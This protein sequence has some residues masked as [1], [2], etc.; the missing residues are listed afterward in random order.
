MTN[1]NPLNDCGCCETPEESLAHL[2]PPG[3]D[4]LAYRIGTHARFKR[5]MVTR[6]PKHQIP[7]GEFKDDRPLAALT[8]RAD[9]DA[10]LAL[11]DAWATAADVLTFYQERIANEGFL[12]T[13]TERLSVLELAREIGYELNPGV[14]ASTYL[15]F[16][17]D[18]SK[19]APGQATIPVGTQVQSLPSKAGELPQTFETSEEMTAQ[20]EWNAL[21][22]LSQLLQTGLDTQKHLYLAGTNTQLKAGDFVLVDAGSPAFRQ[23]LKVEPDREKNQTKVVFVAG[24]SAGQTAPTCEEDGVPD[25]DGLAFN[26]TNIQTYIL[27]KTWTESHL[28]VF[29]SMNQW[30]ADDLLA[31]VS[32]LVAE[33]D[34]SV[35]A[36]RE[37]T[38]IFG[39]TAPLYK[40]LPK[41]TRAPFKNWDKGKGWIIWKDNVT[42]S[43]YTGADVFLDRAIDGIENK[44]WIVLRNSAGNALICKVD[45]VVENSV[46]G[47]AM[48]AKVTGLE[49][50]DKNGNSLEDV[51]TD[52]PSKY[53]LRK[54]T[55]YVKS[56]PLDLAALPVTDD[57]AASAI[58]ITLDGMV[59]G[60]KEGQAIALTGE[61]ADAA[62][63][64]HS[65]ILTLAQITH[66][67]GYTTLK[68]D[69]GL[70]YTY[71]RETVTINANVVAAT[72]GETVASE[73]LGSGNGA[74]T[75]QRFKLKKPPLTHVSAAT[76]SGAEST[77][78][79]RVDGVEW[80]QAST[81]YGLEKNSRNY[82][83]RIDDDANATVIFGD[84]KQG[85]RLPTGQ[86]NLV[87]TYRSGIGSGGEVGANSLTLLKK[88]PFGA[89]SVT[90]PVPATGAADPEKLEDAR[91]NAPLTVLTLDRIVSLQD[92]ED[93][94]RAFA[95][96][97]K[98][99]A[100]VLWDGEKQVVHVTVAD[101]SGDVVEETSAL[102]QNLLD[103]MQVSRDPLQEVRLGSYLPL[104][105]DLEARVL[106]DPAYL[107]E[108]VESQITDALLATFA[109]EKRAFGQPVTAAEVVST[110]HKI[111][112][113]TAVDLDA[114]HK[115][116][117]G[118]G[119]VTLASVLSANLPRLDATGKILPAELIL[120]NEYGITL[121]EVKTL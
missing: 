116:T 36:F 29:L 121:T 118:S 74:A 47:F 94:A 65:E 9:D 38:G 107:W 19:G 34:E 103:A 17:V 117:A 55:A 3:Q 14:S 73:F 63:V 90:N 26:E 50:K 56:E 70:S 32:A 60:L 100:V 30:N 64:I 61:Q 6:L 1:S 62:G 12:R 57:L 120:I 16:A 21:R 39:N 42:G 5:R 58:K 112:G 110:I 95:G 28:Q 80:E 97:G 67:G 106:I 10:S 35:Y 91:T 25:V 69:S 45:K 44:S 13:A 85:A 77:L 4:Q 84:G 53:R 22:P 59:L 72:H 79:V 99:L 76:T 49:L 113:V 31:Y 114:L 75:H 81:L 15:A 27:A 37:R 96:V 52:K 66:C 51:K 98:A 2:N 11:L 23:I 40:S 71:K 20:A 102:F 78:S 82:I 92:Y 68:F 87:A 18:D 88:R 108:N 89:K 48:S 119:S 101:A 46:A 43:F 93:F 7:D 24:S 41:D 109:F 86:N 8:T 33:G 105:F 83:V 111:P 104:S 115:T 54:T